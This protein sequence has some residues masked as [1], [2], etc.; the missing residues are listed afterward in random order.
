MRGN[1]RPAAAGRPGA[2]D[3]ADFARYLLEREGVAV[4]PGSAFGLAPF[5]RISYATA[6][7]RLEEAGRR[8]VR[9]CEA[10]D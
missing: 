2:S 3:D 10:L 4:V 7:E 1:D 5:F 8:I 9:A 6:T